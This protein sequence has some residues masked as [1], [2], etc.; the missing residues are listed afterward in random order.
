MRVREYVSLAI[1]LAFIAIMANPSIAQALTVTNTTKYGS[2]LKAPLADQIFIYNASSKAV[3]VWCIVKDENPDAIVG[4]NGEEFWVYP[5]SWETMYVTDSTNG[6]AAVDCFAM[7]ETNAGGF[8]VSYDYL[9]GTASLEGM[10]Y[11]MWSFAANV[12]TGKRV[13]VAGQIRLTGK[14]GGYD[15]CPASHTFILPTGLASAKATFTLAKEDLRQD[16]SP[17]YSRARMVFAPYTTSKFQ[18]IEDIIAPFDLPFRNSFSVV[19][20][21]NRTIC[22]D[23]A[24]ASPLFGLV[25]AQ[26]PGKDPF[27]IMSTGAGADGTG[28]ILFDPP[29]PTYD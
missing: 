9:I 26:F 29:G 12:A 7:K 13:G 6:P 2:L 24:V 23:T 18:C 15:A 14:S 19:G 21:S 17:I 25:I 8:Q 28:F 27:L 22:D 10:T 20:L 1:L 5:R 3:K 11:P 16:R 4:C